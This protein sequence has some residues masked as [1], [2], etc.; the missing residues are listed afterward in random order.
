M[1]P[2]E[3]HIE[4][5]DKQ[6]LENQLENLVRQW[7][8]KPEPAKQELKQLCGAELVQCV[9]QLSQTKLK[10]SQIVVFISKEEDKRQIYGLLGSDKNDYFGRH[11]NLIVAIRQALRELDAAINATEPQPVYLPFFS[12]E[13]AIIVNMLKDRMRNVEL[14][15]KTDNLLE[16]LKK[17][18]EMGRE[19]PKRELMTEVSK[20]FSEYQYP[21][22]I[23][24][25]LS[26][27]LKAFYE[28]RPRLVI[29]N[30]INNFIKSVENVLVP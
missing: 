22:E 16:G 2:E 19:T 30:K 8:L 9:Q 13:D 28:N 3:N 5:S 4:S 18:R 21:E 11:L 24:N 6:K 17:V 14:V 12:D 23:K 7:K 27:Q 26:Q 20:L 15:K 25:Y 29:N 1:Q 10:M